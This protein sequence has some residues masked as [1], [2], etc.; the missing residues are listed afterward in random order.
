MAQKKPIIHFQDI[1]LEFSGKK[2]FDDCQFSVNAHD[3]VV[4]FGKSGTGKSTLL[5]VILGFEQPQQGSVYIKNTKLSPQ[6]IL[7]LRSQIAYVDQDVMIGEGIVKEIIN[8][9]FALSV[10]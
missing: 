3:K 10:N 6:T 8:Q 1:K 7:K 9:Y 5:K 2:I 4:I